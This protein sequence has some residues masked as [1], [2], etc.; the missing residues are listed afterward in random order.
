MKITVKVIIAIVIVGIFILGGVQLIKKTNDVIP[1][2]ETKETPKN[3]NLPNLKNKSAS[4]KDKN[5]NLS[6]NQF[7]KNKRKKIIKDI[8]NSNL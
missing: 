4:K 7:Y 1:I 2:E 3:N 5:I 8:R 6:K